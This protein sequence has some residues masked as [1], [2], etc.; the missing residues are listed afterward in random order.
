M[1]EAFD[2]EHPAIGRKADLAQLGEIVKTP[3]DPEVVGVVDGR[4]S[5]QGAMFFVVLLDARVLVVD[6]QGWGD[7]VR[8]HAGAKS[9]RR[10]ARGSALED[11]LHLLGSAG[12]EVLTDHLLE[13]QA[14]VLRLIEYLGQ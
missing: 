11:Q 14:A 4:L 13:E 8:D 2:L 12:I 7:V 1:A 10:P 9:P 6:D 3:A 5:T